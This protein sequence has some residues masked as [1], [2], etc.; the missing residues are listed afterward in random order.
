MSSVLIKKFLKFL[1]EDERYDKD[2]IDILSVCNETGEDGDIAA[3]KIN[4]LLGRRYAE[5]KKDKT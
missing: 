1:R 3:D 5:N 4:K 2:F